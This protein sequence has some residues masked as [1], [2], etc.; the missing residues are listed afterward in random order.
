MS[1]SNSIAVWTDP[2]EIT[3]PLVAIGPTEIILAK[4]PRDRLDEAA[5]QAA[6]GSIDPSWKPKAI[7]F[8]DLERVRFNSRSNGT[9]V[10][11]RFQTGNKPETKT[12]GFAK[13]EHRGEFLEALTSKTAGQMDRK[14]RVTTPI[15]AAVK[16]GI[17]LIII[18]FLSWLSI[19][20]ALQMDREGADVEITGRHQGMKRI[21]VWLV[22][23]LGPTGTMALGGG[24]VVICVIYLA[25]RIAKPPVWEELRS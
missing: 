12:I 16:P 6:R 4:P 24:L 17:W 18:S 1:E 21:F 8:E 10:W 9:D 11:I 5:D 3:T 15:T 7:G 22:D 20:A 19:Q 14:T 2:T 23:T 13:T 25:F